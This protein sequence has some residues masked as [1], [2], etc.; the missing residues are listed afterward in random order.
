MRLLSWLRKRMANRSQHG[1][2]TFRPQLEGLEDRLTPSTFT[3]TNV[4]DSG[5]GSLR[6]AVTSADGSTGNTIV[7]NI[8]GS[9]VQT[10]APLMALPAL[11]QAHTT[12][13][14]YTQ[15]GSSPNTRAAS[16]NAVLLIELNGSSAGAGVDGLDIDAANC[17][18]E[19]LAINRFGGNGITVTGTSG[20][21]VAGNFIGT[22]PTGTVAEGNGNA[23]I[24][25]E[26]S[27][28]NTIGGMAAGARNILSGNSVLGN[29]GSVGV[30]FG[31]TSSNNRV[32]GNYIGL[33]AAGNAALP[34]NY[35]VYFS[36]TSQNNVV[37][38]TTAAA[39]NVISGND[40]YGV[41]FVYGAHNTVEGNYLGTDPTGTSALSNGGAQIIV[42]SSNNVIGG[43]APGAG[44]VI[45]GGATPNTFGLNADGIWFIN[46]PN[47]SNTVQHN[48]IGTTADGTTALGNVVGVALDVSSNHNTIGGTTAA[49]RNVISGNTE[50]GVEIT[51]SS[52]TTGNTVA[53][54]W[55]GLNE[56]GT[57]PLPNGGDGVTITLNASGNA[58]G[59]TASGAGNLIEY[60]G[61]AGVD[62]VSGTGD[63]ILG[64]GIYG[65]TG[66][67]IVLG[68]GANNNQAAPQIVF[69][70]AETT[71]TVIEGALLAAPNTTYTVEFFASPTA[72]P[73]GFGQGQKFLFRTTVKTDAFGLGTFI[74]H[75]P[76]VPAG[77]F[78]TA[79][80]TDSGGDTSTFSNAFVVS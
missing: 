80:A 49:A 79:T 10:I 37:G 69:A 17:I 16:D 28:G 9:G 23:G 50:E 11:T 58:I 1:H 51:G 4:N 19:G 33:N 44:N 59:G 2:R 29:E 30:L 18:V 41:A 35:G 43:T 12:I 64:N 39:R 48:L 56:A 57:A 61:G 31:G 25:V 66:G 70:K 74:V 72:D 54:N 14:G 8:P 55:I 36:G 24:L 38:G 45:S 75:L 22:D 76:F 40:S 46:G 5:P 26:S 65:N 7:F 21:T 15:P 32:E 42:E 78:I 63:A 68:P 34:N 27:N 3:V 53:G 13:N 71:Q 47:A 20:A 60:N 67:G 62:V 6:Q 77:Q 52:T 73:S